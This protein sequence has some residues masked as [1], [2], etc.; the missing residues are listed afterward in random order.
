MWIILLIINALVGLALF[1]FAWAA[2]KR[3]RNLDEVRDSRF[4]AWRRNDVKHWSRLKLYPVALTLMPV[5]VIG[6]VLANVIV[7]CVNK[8]ILFGLDLEKPIPVPR[9]KMTKIVFHIGSWAMS[10][11]NGNFPIFKTVDKDYSY[12]LGSDYKQVNKRPANYRVPT[13]VSNHGSGWDPFLMIAT[14]K[15]DVSFL[16]KIEVKSIPFIGSGVIAQE[17]LFCPRGGTADAKEQTVQLIASRQ[18]EIH[19]GRSTKSPLVIFPEGT[20]SNG[21]SILPFRRGAF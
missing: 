4:P 17:G 7:A 18:L 9:R 5:R 19:E 12:W 10:F 14:F 2:T 3:Y 13:Y 11:L 16:A 8:V 21:T 1:E 20:T 15:A 6:F